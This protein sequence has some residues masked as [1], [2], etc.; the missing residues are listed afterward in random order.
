MQLI[1]FHTVFQVLVAPCSLLDKPVS[2]TMDWPEEDDSDH[3]D[4]EDGKSEVQD[5]ELDV[6]MQAQKEKQNKFDPIPRFSRV[7][8]VKVASHTKVFSCSC[9]NQEQMGMPCRHIGSVC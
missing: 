5:E 3:S 7:Y 1:G 9:C 8:E 6:D 2:T 4:K